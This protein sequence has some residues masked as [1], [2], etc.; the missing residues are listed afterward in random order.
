M[1]RLSSAQVLAQRNILRGLPPNLQHACCRHLSILSS[2]V[3]NAEKAMKTINPIQRKRW[4]YGKN[5]EAWRAALIADLEKELKAENKRH[6]TIHTNCA[7]QSQL[8]RYAV[9]NDL[10]SVISVIQQRV[11]TSNR[12]RSV[13]SDDDQF[14]A[15]GLMVVHRSVVRTMKI[16]EERNSADILAAFFAY[17]NMWERI[18]FFGNDMKV[19]SLLLYDT[20]DRWARL[21]NNDNF[22]DEIEHRLNALENDV[23]QLVKR[24]SSES[25]LWLTSSDKQRLA[26]LLQQ[27]STNSKGTR[28]PPEEEASYENKRLLHYFQ[29]PILK[30]SYHGNQF[31]LFN[32]SEESYM[33]K[34]RDHI[35][36]ERVSWLYAANYVQAEDGPPAKKCAEELIDSWGWFA[37]IRNS[38]ERLRLERKQSPLR[39]IAHVVPPTEMAKMILG[40]IK[41]VCSQGQ[42]LIPLTSFQYDLVTPVLRSVNAKFNKILEIDESNVWTS[43]FRSYIR[44]FCDEEISRLYTH[45]EWW[46]KCCRDFGIHPLAQA[47]FEDLHFEAKNQ[48]ST[49]LQEIILKSCQFPVKNNHGVEHAVDAF[50]IRNVAIEE[51]SRITEDSRVT[52]SRMLAINTKL[53]ELFDEHPF[54]YIVFPTHQLPMTV[55]PRPWC[56]GGQGGPEYTRS[57]PVL[58]NLA[59]YKHIDIN[60]QMQRR[61]KSPAQARPVFDALNQLGSTPWII[62][63]P[64]L[65]VLCQIFD[66]SS[67]VSK[68]KLLDILSVPLRADT[69]KVPEFKDFS[70]GDWQSNGTDGHPYAGYITKKA[71]AIKKKNELNSLWYW[72][73]YRIVLANHFRKKT[74]YFPHNMDFRGRVYPISPYLSHMGDD[75]NRCL[76]KFAKG[77]PLGDRG[78]YWLKLHCINLTGKM[79]RS[80]IADRLTEAD[81]ALDDMIDSANNPL[82]GCGWWLKSEEPWQTLAACMELRDALAYPGKLEDFVSHLA[83]H[84]DGSCNGLQH[85]AALGRDEEG[86]REV[87]L[88]S[89]PTPN[90]VYSSVAARVEQ[91]RVQDEKSGPDMEI[92]RRLREVLPQPVPRKVIKQTVMTTVY[93]VTLYGAALQI[94]R[95]LKALDI[96]NELTARFA[97][98]LTH[99]TFAS[100]HDAFT[101]SMKLKDWFRDCAKGVSDLLQTMEWVTPLGLP[102]VQPYVI[103]KEKQGRIIHV[104]VSTKQVGA[105]PPNLIHSLDS[106]HMMLTSLDCSRRGITFAAVHDCFWTHACSVDEMSRVCREQFVR[107]H[108]EPIVEQYSKWLHSHYL[109]PCVEQ[110]PAEDLAHFKKLFTLHVQPGSL[111]INDVRDSVYFFS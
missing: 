26:E 81:R 78:F 107:L 75:V 25:L 101:C 30:E 63:E 87:N 55:P 58:R 17:S 49:S 48:L 23:A 59:E 15:V 102:V 88:L 40:T 68:N 77:K 2:A 13:T 104:P 92:A 110:M 19:A 43:V 34:F 52:L 18:H 70:G 60:S 71:E 99:K 44:I 22:S 35:G 62:N 31:Q 3:E 96:D 6:S 65:N 66:M 67:D 56:D 50:S 39:L 106:C 28:R 20:F 103:A 14:I 21:R 8:I 5:S 42:H 51:E 7:Q 80:S 73:K 100:L 79:K 76:L 27:Y 46:V 109:G 36:T 47:P 85:Y 82:S 38:L 84:Q 4:K 24:T 57:T 111:D 64:M 90:D 11:R 91:K 41:T 29:K 32:T 16:E 45:R 54:R 9:L 94:K 33:K 83:V 61:L 105:F 1:F 12:K 37:A 10:P 108:S 89:S 69:V 93:G 86:G 74:L 97:Q 72:M 53:I 98:Y 95:Q